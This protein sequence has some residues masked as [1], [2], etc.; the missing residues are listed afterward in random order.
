MTSP[1]YS[2]SGYDVTPLANDAVKELA[3]ALDEDVFAIT[4][5]SG[6]EQPFCGNLLDNK[7]SGLYACVVCGLPL[8]SSD[9]K[10]TSGTGW[11]SFW[12][13]FDAL[14]VAEH[15]D[16]RHGMTRTEL[17]CARCNAHLGH[18]FKDGPRPTGLR[19]CLNSAS[20]VFHDSDDE[21]PPTSR[22]IKT[23]TAYFAGGCFWGVEHWFQRGPGVI[24]AVSGYMQGQVEDPTYKQVS[25]GRS[26]HAE[27]VMVT[28]DPTVLSYG[29]L[30]E[31]FFVMH[32]PTQV[33]RQ[34]PDIGAHYRSGI[35]CTSEAQ[36]A[37]ARAFVEKMASSDAFDAPIATQ[38]ETAGTF[39]IAED[40]HQDYIERTGRACHHVNPWASHETVGHSPSSSDP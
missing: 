40:G 25:S 10:Y 20:L 12:T 13:P 16:T 28:W 19:Y 27:S 37:E 15:N 24:N 9:H 4:Q 33:D 11:P 30:L 23:Q 18:I 2:R 22:P 34:G 29:E 32:D 38:V 31:A 1:N 17:T 8:F 6:T 3:E 7:R 36:L 5:R 14:H 26:G 21:L 35:W 39:Y